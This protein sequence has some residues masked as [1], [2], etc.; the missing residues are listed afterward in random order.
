MFGLGI[1]FEWLLRHHS[2]VPTQNETFTLQLLAERETWIATSFANAIYL[3]SFV[4]H[5]VATADIAEK[6]TIL[7]INEKL[8]RGRSQIATR[9]QTDNPTAFE[10]LVEERAAVAH[11]A[12]QVEIFRE[13][14]SG[15]MKLERV[16]FLLFQFSIFS[17]TF[18]KNQISWLYNINEFQMVWYTFS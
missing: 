14:L 11:E 12:F 6:A 5:V 17:L 8:D 9:V 10:R 3:E 4:Q 13:V 18:P 1:S 2:R 16:C 15:A 7:W